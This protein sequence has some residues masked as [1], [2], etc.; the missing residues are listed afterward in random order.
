[1]YESYFSLREPAFSITPDSRFLWLSAT[2]EEASGWRR[3]TSGPAI[4]RSA[5]RA[6]WVRCALRAAS[7]FRSL[8]GWLAKLFGYKSL[9]RASR[10][11]R[12]AAD[13]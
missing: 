9:S 13:S 6:A 8:T 1:M 4:H 7:L 10:L 12:Q 3:T 2:A 11:H 5:P